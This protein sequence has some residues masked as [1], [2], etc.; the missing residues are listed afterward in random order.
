MLRR[1][2]LANKCLLLFGAAVVLIIFAALAVPLFRMSSVVDEGQREVSRRMIDVYEGALAGGIGGG[3]GGGVG[4]EPMV[5]A[6]GRVELI[7]A[8]RA[9]EERKSRPF[10]GESWDALAQA[11]GLAEHGSVRTEGTAREYGLARGVRDASG[12][13]QAMIVLERR[14]PEASRELL[15]NTV[16]LGSAGAVALGMAVLTFYLITSKLILG[17]VRDLRDTAEEVRRGNLETRSTIETGD[18]FEE[19]AEAFNGM[20]TG[21]Q[22]T[23]A[24][25][26][27]INAAL[28]NRVIDLQ[29]QNSMLEGANRVKG[30]FLANVSHELR[31]P[32]NSILGFADLLLEAAEKEVAAGD[33]SMRLAKRRRYV[34]NI[35]SSGRT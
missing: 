35:Q 4:G 11:P 9:T 17:P 26:R 32:L 22:E 24:K 31:T 3:V 14:S 13:L 8:A 25:L 15:V 12:A 2:S 23:E 28:D 33:D 30:E 21:L 29:S 7:S 1:V 19:L 6:G 16:Y 20:L 27:S 34:E 10:V 5:L 18:E